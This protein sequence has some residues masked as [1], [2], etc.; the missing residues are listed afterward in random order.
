M[1]GQNITIDKLKI[2]A[3]NVGDEVDD[4]DDDLEWRRFGGPVSGGENSLP[5]LY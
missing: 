4:D 3:V 2:D 1:S 5:C